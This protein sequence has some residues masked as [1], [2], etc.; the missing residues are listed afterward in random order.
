MAWSW[1]VSESGEHGHV[2]GR[3]AWTLSTRPYGDRQVSSTQDG[4]PPLCAVRDTAFVQF[5]VG[6]GGSARNRY[7][8]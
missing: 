7:T 5:S 6:L 4:G 3:W 2:C 8:Q 1:V